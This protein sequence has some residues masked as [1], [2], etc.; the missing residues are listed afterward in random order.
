MRIFL[1]LPLLGLAVWFTSATQVELYKRIIGGRDCNPDEAQYQVFLN[2]G[3]VVR[4]DVDACGG[5]LLSSK[6]IL[7]AAHCNFKDL[8]LYIG[9]RNTDDIKNN[10]VQPVEVERK[11]QHPK[12]N[13]KKFLNDIMLI[14]LKNDVPNPKTVKLPAICDHYPEVNVP[15]KR[16]LLVAGWG[17]LGEK[18]VPKFPAKL[19]CAEI[20]HAV[21]PNI[22]PKIIADAF[23]AGGERKNVGCG[24]SGGGVVRTARNEVYG[25]VKAGCSDQDP[26]VF[27][28]V[29]SHLDWIKKETKL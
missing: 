3:P 23:C 26:S 28:S 17:S 20:R 22:D 24:D 29:C 5:S 16:D 18:K 12:Y 9:I 1:L 6:W 8:K 11:I 14:K 4:D 19:Q 2:D 7:T 25:V 27:T 21:C 13:A 15:T 10:N